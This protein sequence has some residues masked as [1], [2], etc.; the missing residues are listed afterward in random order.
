MK[1]SDVVHDAQRTRFTME[2][3][4]GQAVLDYGEVAA[5]T[6]NF[7]HTFVPPPD[8][9]QG[10]ASRVVEAAMSYARENGFTVVP[11]CSY[12]RDWLRRNPGFEDLTG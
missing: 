1:S 9:G 10:I 4:H 8:R 2:T 12:V 6:L 11:G 7:Y 5:K 3:P